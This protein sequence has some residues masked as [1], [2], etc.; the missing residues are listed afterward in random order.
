MAYIATV[1]NYDHLDYEKKI[2]KLANFYESYMEACG[3]TDTDWTA[4]EAA[5]KAWDDAVKMGWI[6]GYFT[7]A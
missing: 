5:N 6:N 7:E 2:C 3:L 4:K 1:Q